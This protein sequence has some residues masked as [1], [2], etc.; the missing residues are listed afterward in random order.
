VN[1]DDGTRF[2][3]LGCRGDWNFDGGVDFNDLLA[4]PDVHSTPC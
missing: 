2:V 3:G 1:Q 4:F